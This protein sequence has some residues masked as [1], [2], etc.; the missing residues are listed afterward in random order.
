MKR[1]NSKPPR[2]FVPALVAGS[3]AVGAVASLLIAI[4]A[5]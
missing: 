4:A 2:W 3:A 1:K 5:E